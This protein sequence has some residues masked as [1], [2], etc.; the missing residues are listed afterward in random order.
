M[1]MFDIFSFSKW[2]KFI[3]FPIGTSCHCEKIITFW[4]E[5]QDRKTTPRKTGLSNTVFPLYILKKNRLLY[6]VFNQHVFFLALNIFLILYFSLIF[7]T[8]V[9]CLV[10]VSCLGW[11]SGGTWPW[12]A[13]ASSKL[14]TWHDDGHVEFFGMWKYFL[15]L[16]HY[17]Q[18]VVMKVLHGK[19]RSVIW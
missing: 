3:M 10:M 6:F 17:I 11:W 8:V 5:E 1:W 9:T 16:S 4:L 13:S 12:S 14:L 7:W 15:Q 18:S 19:K 2:R